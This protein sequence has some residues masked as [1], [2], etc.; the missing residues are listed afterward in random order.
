MGSNSEKSS[1]ILNASSN[2]LGFCFVV[3]TSVKL[4]GFSDATYLDEI[5]AVALI[6]FMT[7]CILSFMSLRR[8]HDFDIYERIADILFLTG[9]FILFISTLLFSFVFELRG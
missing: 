2:L 6:C 8:N 4:L 7:S 1:H 3:L 9:L 5:T